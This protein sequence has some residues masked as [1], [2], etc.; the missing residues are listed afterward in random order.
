ML[1]SALEYSGRIDAEYYKPSFLEY[2]NIITAKGGEALE[3]LSNFLIGPF[4]SAFTVDN[5]TD[6]KTYRYIRGKD[7]KPLRLDDSDNVYMPKEDYE[8]LSRYALKENDILVSVVGTIGNAALVTKKDLPAVFSCKNTVLRPH[9]IN[10]IYLLTYIN[11][12][13]GKDLLV[14]KERGAVQK[15]LNLGDIESLLIFKPSK[16]FQNSIEN[17]FRKSFSCIEQSKTT[18]TAA[19]NILLSEIGL[20]D[21]TPSNEP[22]NIKT[23]SESFATSGRLDAEYYQRK[24]EQVIEKITAQPHDTL[25][26]IVTIQKSIE[27]GSAHYAEEGLPFY[28]VADYSKFGMTTPQKYLSSDFVKENAAQLAKLQPKK[29]SILFAKDG[30]VG[31]AY[32]LTEDINGIT[33]GAILQLRVQDERRVLPEYLTL[34]LNSKLVQM[35]AERD[36]GGSIILHW[37]V[38]EIENVVVPIIPLPKQSEIAALITQSFNLKKQSEHLLEVAKRAVEIAIEQDEAAA[39]G[40]IAEQTREQTKAMIA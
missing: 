34:A 38:S 18:Y 15:G 7:C 9:S 21:F 23:F 5:Y 28:R 11:T 32:H 16:P 27:P 39:M 1:L 6:D 37:R 35:Q 31:E 26:N 25:A 30:S 24:Y 3:N 33:S 40:W 20:T 4:G 29:G 19:E 8:R 14:R 12:K 36:A 22:V 2:E 10:P 13:Y 17:L